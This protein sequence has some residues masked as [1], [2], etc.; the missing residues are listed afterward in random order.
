M[1]IRDSI[2]VVILLFLSTSVS[3]QKQERIQIRRGNRDFQKEQY[4][5]A[6]VK[7][8]KALELNP[9]S[10]E[11]YYNLA[12]ALVH[13][14]KDSLALDLYSKAASLCKDAKKS[15]MI[16]HNAGDLYMA[17]KKYQEAVDAFKQSLRKDPTND[18]TR[19]NLALAQK[20][21]KDQQKQQ[22]QQK[23]DDKKKDQKKDKDKQKQNKD[24][25]KPNPQKS[26]P[27]N[28][29]PQDSKHRDKMSKQNAEQLLKAA[30]QDEK[31]LRER[32]K[33]RA[34]AQGK[35]LDKDW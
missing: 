3:A 21:L 22:K 7:Y 34:P 14:K 26:N 20:Q 8:R 15:A 27:Q 24:Q 23:K 29:K 4:V 5:D 2:I 31:Q 30:M 19:Y 35:Q 17:S 28:N 33:N 32:M 10:V 18:Q 1:K 12:G 11:A 9:S 6:E 25:K 13:Q 16:Y